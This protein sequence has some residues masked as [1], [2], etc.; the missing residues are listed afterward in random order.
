MNSEANNQINDEQ[1]KLIRLHQ[2]ELYV[3]ELIWANGQL[4]AKEI[5][6]VI[7]EYIGW[8]KNTTYTVIKRLI[9]K[10]ALKRIEPGFICVAN[11]TK[12]QVQ[13]IETDEL[14]KQLY[15]GRLQNFLVDYLAKQKLSDDDIIVLKKIIGDK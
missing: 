1:N 2:G 6:D 13:Q 10:N 9:E 7:N 3:M 15:D 11:I 12:N 5:A 14:I 4:S 8:K